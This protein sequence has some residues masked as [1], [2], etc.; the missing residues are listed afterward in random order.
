[1]GLWEL[2]AVRNSAALEIFG[3]VSFVGMRVPP[4]WAVGVACVPFEYI[5]PHSLP[6]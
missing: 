4:R 6:G 1:M 2:P 3:C 5:L